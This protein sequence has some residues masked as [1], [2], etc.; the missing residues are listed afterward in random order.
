MY[1]KANDNTKNGFYINF[2]FFLHINFFF[3]I[4]SFAIRMRDFSNNSMEQYRK[5]PENQQDKRNKKKGKK[6][7][8][9]RREL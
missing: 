5:C 3:I 4:R 7:K 8:A 1:E 6:L 2:L 9:N